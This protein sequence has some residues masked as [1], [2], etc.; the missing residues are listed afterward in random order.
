MSFHPKIFLD[1][2]IFIYLFKNFFQSVFIIAQNIIS[3][4]ILTREYTKV[5]EFPEINKMTERLPWNIAKYIYSQ[6]KITP[7]DIFTTWDI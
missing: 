5:K 2:Q 1:K 3:P 7:K 6:K 4:D